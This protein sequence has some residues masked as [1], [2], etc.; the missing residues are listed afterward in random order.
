VLDA[1]GAADATTAQRVIARWKRATVD[2][3][4]TATIARLLTR[5]APP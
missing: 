4:T 1:A 3:A 5:T 2:G